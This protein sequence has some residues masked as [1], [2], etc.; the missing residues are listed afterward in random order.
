M[1]LCGY[2]RS[3]VSYMNPENITLYS[4]PY[5]RPKVNNGWGF[6]ACLMK[7]F[8]LYFYV[9]ARSAAR[10]HTTATVRGK[11]RK[12][13]LFPP[14]PPISSH[15]RS[16]SGDRTLTY[17]FVL[18]LTESQK[19]TAMRPQ[20]KRFRKEAPYGAGCGKSFDVQFP[21]GNSMRGRKFDCS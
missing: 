9:E 7:F 21:I 13:P 8:A 10:L 12:T 5:F 20:Q 16:F 18:S 19:R 11:R 14:T 6:F 3:S 4:I 15:M 2:S 1:L 17:H